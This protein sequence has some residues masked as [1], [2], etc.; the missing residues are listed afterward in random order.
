MQVCF[1]WAARQAQD[2]RRFRSKAQRKSYSPTSLPPAVPTNESRD[3]RAHL[4]PAFCGARWMV[5]GTKSHTGRNKGSTT[6]GRRSR[7]TQPC[8][9]CP[10]HP[11]PPKAARGGGPA[12]ARASRSHPAPGRTRSNETRG[13]VT[14]SGHEAGVTG[15]IPRSPPRPRGPAPILKVKAAQRRA[16]RSAGRGPR[17]ELWSSRPPPRR[18]SPARAI[19][20]LGQTSIYIYIYI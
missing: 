17:V 1:V 15:T 3:G 4:P 7:H 10:P 18:R 14:P 20:G 2:K 19:Q 13:G 8:C 16:A 6:G 9:R 5:G 12:S 11:S